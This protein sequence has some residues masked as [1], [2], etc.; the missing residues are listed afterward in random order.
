VT[1]RAVFLDRDG[2][3]NRKA[4]PDAYVTAPEQVELLSGA[5]EAIARFNAAGIPVLVVTNQ[6]GIARGLMDGDD[7][8][9]VHRRLDELLAAHGA[10]VDGY[11][12]CPHAAGT[13]DCR[14]PA[15]GLLLR[16]AEALELD[17]FDQTALVGDAPSDVEAGRRVGARTYLVAAPGAAGADRADELVG[18]LGEAAERL[19]DPSP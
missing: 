19:L 5:G 3:I 11:F 6:R 1:P 8:A 2:T 4:P 7:L 9:A 18:S 14:K 12:V 17:S 16:A 13:C 10:H 15:P